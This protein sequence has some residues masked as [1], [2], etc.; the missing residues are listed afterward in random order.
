MILILEASR[1]SVGWTFRGKYLVAADL[2]VFFWLSHDVV[3]DG[4]QLVDLPGGEVED[5]YYAPHFAPP[6]QLS[7]EGLLRKAIRRFTSS[8]FIYPS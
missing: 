1:R 5:V 6:I 2:V 3:C 8:G 4:Y 7:S